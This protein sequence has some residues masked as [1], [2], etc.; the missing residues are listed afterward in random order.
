MSVVHRL[1]SRDSNGDAR[2]LA[3][4]KRSSGNCGPAG[5][6]SKPMAE[7]AKKSTPPPAEQG[8]SLDRELDAVEAL[9]DAQ[10]RE[11]EQ[12]RELM[13]QLE[14]KLGAVEKILINGPEQNG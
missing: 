2:A 13:D 9:L 12:L 1:L 10:D 6:V 14:N 7:G 11:H 5:P 8:N 3:R 4:P